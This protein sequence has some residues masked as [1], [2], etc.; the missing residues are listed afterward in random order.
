MDHQSMIDVIRAHKEEKLIEYTSRCS[1]G[2]WRVASFPSWNF[3]CYDYRIKPE[4]RVFVLCKGA[5]KRKYTECTID[6]AA[7]DNLCDSAI[8]VR[9]ITE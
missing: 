4:P 2:I 8:R 9:E 5:N 7:D 3:D 6:C 1:D